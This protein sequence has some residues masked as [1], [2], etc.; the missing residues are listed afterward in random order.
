VNFPDALVGGL[1]AAK[2]KAPILLST[3]AT[4]FGAGAASVIEDA[5]TT[6]HATLLGGTGALSDA[7]KTA[8]GNAFLAR[9]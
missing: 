7:V 1:L 3:S 9:N 5:E 2:N 8:V 4:T 6:F